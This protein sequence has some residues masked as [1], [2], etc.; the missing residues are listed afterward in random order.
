MTNRIFDIIFSI[1][2]LFIFIVPIIIISILIILT[3]G[4]PIFHYS[5]RYG[6]EKKI[7]NMPKFRTFKTNSPDLPT[8]LFL[9]PDKYITKI[10]R[11]LRKYSLD[12]L[13]QIFSV[14]KGDMSIVGPR[15]ALH[16]QNDLINLRDRY[17]INS[18]YP[19]IT[20]YAQ[21]NGR[22]K[23][24]IEEKVILEKYYYDNAS[25]KLKIKIIIKTAIFFL[26][27]RDVKH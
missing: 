11:Y 24:T 16:N 7:F 15:P 10:G 25:F 22:D 26:S 19:G 2:L 14:L 18:M 8:H 5:K 23:N 13:P 27:S 21:I 20:G 12:E 1:F 4:L 9:Q 6:L 3:S 17:N